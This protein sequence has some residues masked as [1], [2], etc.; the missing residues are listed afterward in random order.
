[1]SKCGQRTSFNG[2]DG[3][4][5]IDGQNPPE[6]G[7]NGREHMSQRGQ[8]TSFNPRQSLP[9][10]AGMPSTMRSSNNSSAPQGRGYNVYA[11]SAISAG[12]DCALAAT[13]NPQH[14]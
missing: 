2:A 7:R 1:M 4:S 8:R 13:L 9:A 11:S 12:D 10:V 5:D 3:I 14:L 6:A